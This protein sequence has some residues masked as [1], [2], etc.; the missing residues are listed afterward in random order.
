VPSWAVPQP[1]TYAGPP[2]QATTN[3]LAIA[4]LVTSLVGVGVVGVILGHIALAQIKRL[5]QAGRG[6]A[7]AGVI[8][9]YVGIGA[10]VLFFAV[11]LASLSAQ[12]TD[13]IDS[14]TTS[15]LRNAYI[16]VIAY[17]TEN[18]EVDEVPSF[19]DGTLEPYGFQL[20]ESTESIVAT[21]TYST[22]V[23]LTATSVNGRQFQVGPD[24]GVVDLN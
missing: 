12:S 13:A 5:G 18:P 14:T 8:I 16:A 24:G 9:G 20:S 19:T 22:G 10:T 15:D 4:S 6:M 3:G 1:V 2:P 17:G 23:V 7:L 21:G 11:G